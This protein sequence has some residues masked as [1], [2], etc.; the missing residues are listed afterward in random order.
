MNWG[1]FAALW[2][3][4]S[5]ACGQ[6]A[7]IARHQA[8][9]F[10]VILQSLP[11]DTFRFIDLEDGGVFSAMN[12]LLLET[13]ESPESF[14]AENV[15]AVRSHV[16]RALNGLASRLIK[17]SQ[18]HS[19]DEDGG[20][21][22]DRLS[23]LIKVE[24]IIDPSLW[25]G[26]NAAALNL[27]DARIKR[28]EEL[29]AVR[30]ARP[31]TQEEKEAARLEF[32]STKD[33]A[34]KLRLAGVL[35]SRGFGL[36]KPLDLLLFLHPDDAEEIEDFYGGVNSLKREELASSMF[37]DSD[38]MRGWAESVRRLKALSPKAYHSGQESRSLRD[39][40]I[41]YFY[42][43]S[44][45]LA[46]GI[47]ED[48]YRLPYPLRHGAATTVAPEEPKAVEVTQKATP[49]SA[50][51]QWK[52]RYALFDRF[53][54]SNFQVLQ[55]MAARAGGLTRAS[56]EGILGQVR[57][58]AEL[59]VRLKA[60]MK[61]GFP[62]NPAEDVR[63]IEAGLRA[64]WAPLQADEILPRELAGLVLTLDPEKPGGALHSIVNWM[65]QKALSLFNFNDAGYGANTGGVSAGWNHLY[66][67]YLGGE[68][69]HDVLAGNEMIKGCLS[70]L[71]RMPYANDQLYFDEGRAWI[72]AKFGAHS[73]E[74]FADSS[75]PDEGGALR[76]R[77]MESGCSGAAQ[78]LFMISAFLRLFGMS[79]H[80][81]G[82][83]FL[84]AVWDK[85]HGLRSARS[86]A[87]ALP[88]ILRFLHDTNDID[89]MFAYKLHAGKD[90]PEPLALAMAEA[91]FAEGAWPF[92]KA[93]GFDEFPG[94]F[95]EY[96]EKEPA[97]SSLRGRLD[98]ELKRLGLAPI[99][100]EA[101][102][103]QRI[104]DLFFTRP[105]Q[106]ALARGELAAGQDGV[107]TRAP[108]A[109]L[110]GLARADDE[111]GEAL[112]SALNALDG[113]FLDYD[114]IGAVGALRAERA[115]KRLDD[116]SILTVH[117]LREPASGR[118]AFARASVW[119]SSSGTKRLGRSR[120]RRVLWLNGAKIEDAEEL[121]A[122]Q[123]ERLRALLNAPVVDR[124][125]ARAFGIPA[126]SG[127]GVGP[128][129]FDRSGR[130]R[131]A[132]LAAPYTSPDDLEAI[133]G[134][135][136]VITT[137]GGSLSHAAIT[138]RELGIASVILPSARW[139]QGGL[140]LRM[141]RQGPARTLENGIQVAELKTVE[142]PTLREG[143]I[144]RIDGRT[145]E[146]ILN[147]GPTEA[148]GPAAPKE[149]PAPPKPREIDRKRLDE[150]RAKRPS[151]LKLDEIIEDH[152]QF[153]GGKSAKLGE[154]FS[155]LKGQDAYVPDGIAL[156]YWAYERFL[157]ENGLKE[158]MEEL[159]RE[160]DRTG[161]VER[162]SAEIRRTILS[163]RLDPE[164]GL[165]GEILK[166][167]TDKTY[168]VRSSA[169]QED[170][171]D[172][173]FAGAAES[174][175]FVHP[176]EVLSKVVEN[177]A[178]FWLP[179]AVLYRQRH[180]L[181]SVDLRPATLIQEMVAAEKSG[182]LFTRN[183]VT[184]ADEVVINAAYGLGEGVVSGRAAADS[185]TTRKSDG[186]E[187]E[188]ARVARKRWQVDS[189]GSGTR[190]SAVP[191]PLRGKRVLTR[192]Q[193]RSLSKVAAALERRFGRPL[194]V[195]F[196]I[197]EGRIVILQARPI[198]T[199]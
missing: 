32:L 115:Q 164:K 97:R 88:L 69:L 94:L 28:A 117:A 192:E 61:G 9:G 126:S 128:V 130:A 133:A 35:Q 125:A 42:L 119:E 82:G 136:G 15:E 36:S 16:C 169:I 157:S 50:V 121:T 95:S 23:D 194:D 151:L 104:I 196:S 132:I 109:P 85:D 64:G 108:Y 98:A 60:F 38:L 171:D 93:N 129:S 4:P 102:F 67:A 31:W 44:N 75:D 150:I 197:C 120:L 116:G 111:A 182:V 55:A 92:E 187:T 89:M 183:P 57:G 53:I 7:S 147:P 81:E 58:M 74:I 24:Y 25:E 163:G 165:G 83:E 80:L 199:P 33:P 160:L 149:R 29:E 170:T 86:I 180:G 51:R 10:A 174:Y 158:R 113:S 175:L 52:K 59:F 179:R 99:P 189:G 76:I 3:I 2:V 40:E 41:A 154:M 71:S 142:D 20:S 49:P 103:G 13:G 17:K 79:V 105:I 90:K 47:L 30:L 124:P 134:S 188:L 131:G 14:A 195:E 148:A 39:P 6:T 12:R 43:L 144:V 54:E 118:L 172:A 168:S 156:T 176:G 139:A 34:D 37:A 161:E 27:R 21:L 153:V 101:P 155:A 91:Y 162:L 122:P 8:P 66:Y 166:S 190:L 112:A 68:P 26:L 96:L 84:S 145:G 65:H 110:D 73:A 141:T 140:E 159:A 107:P 198:T 137:G 78:R 56:A 193:T 191:K 186:E 173:A 11:P 18:S 48:G 181:L 5:R 177:W 1:L 152:M 106:E 185:Y 178:S 72:H 45:G 135:A 77:Y 184:S 114:P 100:R 46:G 127:D 62:E 22:E 63:R 143:D 70:G 19:P 146:V 123:R 167:L 87:Q 138:T